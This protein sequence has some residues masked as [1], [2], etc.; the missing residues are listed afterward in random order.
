MA[1]ALGSGSSPKSPWSRRSAATSG[2]WKS[3]DRDPQDRWGRAA[4]RT[5]PTRVGT[6]CRPSVTSP[7]L[8]GIGS[9]PKRAAGQMGPRGSA[10]PTHE[11]RDGLPPVRD[12]SP[13]RRHRPHTMPG[14]VDAR[15]RTRHAP[16]SEAVYYAPHVE[17]NSP[18]RSTTPRHIRRRVRHFRS[19]PHPPFAFRPATCSPRQDDARR[20]QTGRRAERHRALLEERIRVQPDAPAPAPIHDCHRCRRRARALDG[21][22]ETAGGDAGPGRAARDAVEVTGLGVADA[23]PSGRPDGR[24]GCDPGL[25]PDS[26]AT[27]A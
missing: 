23:M 9:T 27:F 24:K 14:R 3:P 5:L 15:F 12:F 22:G 17:G 2:P 8:G 10:D 4:A 21:R 18:T 25:L 6:G 7:R 16:A 1:S 19:H 26:P 20:T 11:G 13:G